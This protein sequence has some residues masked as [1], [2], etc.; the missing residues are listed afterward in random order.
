MKGQMDRCI[1]RLLNGWVDGWMHGLLGEW[2]DE[3]M[4]QQARIINNDILKITECQTV[5]CWVQ[6]Q[7]T[8]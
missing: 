2:I 7:S 8:S 5:Q 1:N 6:F 4:G 3:Q